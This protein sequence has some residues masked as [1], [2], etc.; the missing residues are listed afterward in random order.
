MG[1]ES[2]AKANIHPDILGSAGYNVSPAR[3]EIRGVRDAHGSLFEQLAGYRERA[4]RVGYFHGYLDGLKAAGEERP[5]AG[6]H[7][8]PHYLRFLL[9]WLYDSNSPEGAVLKSWV[10]SRFGLAP[11]FHKVKLGGGG[12]A[13]YGSY[14]ETAKACLNGREEVF[15]EFDLLYEFMQHEIALSLGGEVFLTLYRGYFGEAP[16]IGIGMETEVRLNNLNS[17]TREPERAWEF[18]D[19]VIEAKVPLTKVFFDGCLLKTG[20]LTGEEEVIVLGGSYRVRRLGY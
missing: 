17:F 3:L 9:G 11:T 2:G 13:A 18:G 15:T 14:R 12:C 5:R 10:E 19:R 8:K 4:E 6:L 20:I 1:G 7:K 16:H